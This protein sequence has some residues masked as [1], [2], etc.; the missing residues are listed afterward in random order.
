LQVTPELTI[1][2]R[3]PVRILALRHVGP[4]HTIGAAFGKLGGV[5]AALGLPR[6][7]M[8]GVFLDDPK[9]VRAPW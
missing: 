4:F 6:T 9:T 8:L 2:H 7:T 1:V 3:E 5:V